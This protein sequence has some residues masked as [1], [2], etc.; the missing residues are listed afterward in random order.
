VLVV[1]DEPTIRTVARLMLERSGY[2]VEEAGDAAAAVDRVRAAEIPFAAILLDVTLPG[3]SGI[4]VLPDL[5]GAAPRSPVVLTS[6]KP[7][8]DVAGHGADGYL[9]KPFTK[10]QLLAAVRAVGR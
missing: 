3:R 2:A 1:D 6:G 9:P 5:R 7:E 10:E 8:E 4:D